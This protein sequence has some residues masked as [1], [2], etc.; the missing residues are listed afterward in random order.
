MVRLKGK[1]ITLNNTTGNL[2]Q[3]LMVRLKAVANNYFAPLY[4]NLLSV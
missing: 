1:N 2:F 4:F 3:F